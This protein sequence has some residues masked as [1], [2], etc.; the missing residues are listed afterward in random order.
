MPETTMPQLAIPR[1]TGHADPADVVTALRTVGACII[2][3]RLSAEKL[4]ALRADLD[5]LIGSSSGGHDDFHG[6]ETTRIG[7]L[8][9]HSAEV[10]ELATDPLV[11][12]VGSEFLGEWCHRMQLMLTQVIAI[13][14][15]ET[16]Q[17]LHRDR[18]AWGGFIPAEIEPQLNTMWAISDFTADNGATRIVPGS[19]DWDPER[20]ATPDDVLQATMPAGSVLIFTGSVLHSGAAN[21]ST[22]VRVG[23]NIDYCLDWLRQEENQYLSCP[24]EVASAFSPELASLIGYTGG[25]FVLG[26]WSDPHDPTEGK[27]RQAE[28]AVG[29]QVA[30]DVSVFTDAVT[31]A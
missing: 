12:D 14:P 8:L 20:R 6:F 1:F 11:L 3:N 16:D 22:G 4:D 19:A 13:G 25:G 26:Y 5:P 21:E 28:V 23:V 24:P 10:H 31:P 27:T 2:E 15:S 7:A 29:N 9:A 18:L 30:D 17:S